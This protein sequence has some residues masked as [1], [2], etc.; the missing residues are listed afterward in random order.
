MKLVGPVVAWYTPEIPTSFGI[1]KFNGLPGLTLE[2]ITDYDKGKVYYTA[3]KIELNPEEEIKIKKPRGKKLSE[4]EYIA[5]IERLNNAR[6][7][8]RQ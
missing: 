7:S 1:Q 8:Q 4:Q 6:R 2:L 3:T 5:L